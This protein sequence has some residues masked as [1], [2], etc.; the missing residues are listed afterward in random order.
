MTNSQAIS[1]YVPLEYAG[2]R[3]DQVLTELLSDYS[4]A[5]IQ[6][7]IKA[8]AIQVERTGNAAT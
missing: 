6:Q 8:G 5:R 3:L 4:R 2:Q 1:C 7:W